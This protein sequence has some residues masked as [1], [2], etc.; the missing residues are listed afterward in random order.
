MRISSIVVTRHP[1]V[2]VGII[3]DMDHNGLIRVSR[4]QTG[5]PGFWMRESDVLDIVAK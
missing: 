2:P 4:K 3:T 1:R 5:A